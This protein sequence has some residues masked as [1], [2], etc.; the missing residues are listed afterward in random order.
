MATILLV[1]DDPQVAS[2]LET[3]LKAA[4][5]TV[6][7]ADNGIS[8]LRLLAGWIPDVVVTDIS[9]PEKDGVELMLE[10]RRLPASVPVIAMSGH[11]LSDQF[12]KVGR[13]LGALKTL[14]KPFHPEEL[15]A[16]IHEACG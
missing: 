16:A 7:W 11:S 13:Q 8:A 9:M 6:L 14:Q 2:L 4:G 15:V 12:L 1:E 10:L 3:V 5:H